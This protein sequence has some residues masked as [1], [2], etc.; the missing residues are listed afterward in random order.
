MVCGGHVNR[1]TSF[2]V[3]VKLD[4]FSPHSFYGIIIN[5]IYIPSLAVFYDFDVGFFF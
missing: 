3:W 4:F 5:R 1:Y 2:L